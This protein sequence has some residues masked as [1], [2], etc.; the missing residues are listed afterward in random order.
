MSPVRGPDAATIRAWAQET[1]RAVGSRGAIP[2]H[3]HNE[4]VVEQ[5]KGTLRRVGLAAA[6]LALSIAPEL[7]RTRVPRRNSGQ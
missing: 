3:L 4:Y 7:A 2:A 5:V 6:H 1:G